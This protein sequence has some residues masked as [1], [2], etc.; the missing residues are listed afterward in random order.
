MRALLASFR[1]RRN[2]CVMLRVVPIDMD[3][4]CPT[5]RALAPF[6]FL[7]GCTLYV[8]ASLQA[9]MKLDGLKYP[10]HGGG[11]CGCVD[12][13]PNCVGGGGTC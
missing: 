6:C 7:S 1:Y 13:D 4:S 5:L 9:E 2:C 8:S 12:G 10:F 11:G 3:V